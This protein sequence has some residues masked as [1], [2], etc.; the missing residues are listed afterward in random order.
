MMASLQT[1]SG[2]MPH[3][4]PT[5]SLREYY[6]VLFYQCFKENGGKCT[7]A[8]W[9]Q[10]SLSR[11]DLFLKNYSAD[12]VRLAAERMFSSLKKTLD[13]PSKSAKSGQLDMF[14]D[15]QVPSVFMVRD[16]DGFSYVSRS[17][18]SFRD[19]QKHNEAYAEHVSKKVK[20]LQVLQDR[21]ESLIALVDNNPDALIVDA[22][23]KSLRLN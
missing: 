5:M 1:S 21:Y 20:R 22:M 7:Q 14:D 10:Y 8:T 13:A 2:A 18:A 4:P 3:R 6:K 17:I 15:Y 16:R 9:V 19:W 23:K 11:K 12:M